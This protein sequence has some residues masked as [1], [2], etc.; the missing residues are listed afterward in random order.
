MHDPREPHL[1]LIKR[2]LRYINGTLDHGR[3]PY[4]SSSSSC[5]G[6]IAPTYGA[7]PQDI[8]FFLVITLYHDRS[9]GKQ[10]CLVR[11]QKSS[12][13]PFAPVGRGNF[14]MSCTVHCPRLPWYSVTMLVPCTSIQTPSNI[15]SRKHIELDIHFVREKVASGDDRVLH[16]LHH[17]N[18]QIFSQTYL[19]LD[20]LLLR[21]NRSACV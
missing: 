6:L 21:Y 12:T 18:L 5:I 2:I 1:Q 14:F 16:V 4:G 17:H 10:L 15:S 3:H 9:R 7:L 8:M 13:E 19:A 11:T 20:S